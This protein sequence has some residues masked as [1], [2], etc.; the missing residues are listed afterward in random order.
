VLTFPAGEIEPDPAV[1]PGAIDSLNTWTDSAAVF[2]R[3][4][5]ETKIVPVVVS[6]VIWD[7]AARHW[8]PRLKQTRLDR[9]KLAAALQ[10]LALVARNARPNTVHVQFAKPITLGDAGS[11]D[12]QAI[13][14][15]LIQR[16]K[17]LLDQQPGDHGVSVL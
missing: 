15:I 12:P 17:T 10:L 6:G 9:E 2:I 7:K 1:Y 4:A 16:M 3:F 8:L 13:H 11:T 14:Q 5:P